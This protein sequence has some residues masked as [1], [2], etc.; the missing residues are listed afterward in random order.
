MN[1]KINPDDF[2]EYMKEVIPDT[3]TQ[4]KKLICDWSN[5]KTI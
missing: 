1:E 3:Y 4:N 5:K 2:S